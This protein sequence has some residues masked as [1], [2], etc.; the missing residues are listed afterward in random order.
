MKNLTVNNKIIIA[1][2]LL[3][4]IGLGWLLNNYYY[5]N[6]YDLDAAIQRLDP[7]YDEE[8]YLQLLEP[9]SCT[10]SS[11]ANENQGCENLYDFSSNGWTK[12]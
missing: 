2:T 10:S 6:I 3:V 4:G 11:Q 5:A 12:L 8:S 7:G 1:I 9:I